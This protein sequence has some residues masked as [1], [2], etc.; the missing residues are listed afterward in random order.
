MSETSPIISMDR[1][2]DRKLLSVGPVLS[3]YDAKID[4]D[5]GELLVKDHQL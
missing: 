4:P 5:T 1:G 3:S 2:D